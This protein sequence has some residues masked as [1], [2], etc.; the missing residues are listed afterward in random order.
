MTGITQTLKVRADERMA[1]SYARE[2]EVQIQLGKSIT[3]TGA[4]I[5]SAVL[6]GTE[7]PVAPKSLSGTGVAAPEFKYSVVSNVIY[8]YAEAGNGTAAIDDDT[9]YGSFTGA[10]VKRTA[11]TKVE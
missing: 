7:S 2:I 11:G 10:K 3:G 9:K 1:D 5:T 4:E 8:V 6:G